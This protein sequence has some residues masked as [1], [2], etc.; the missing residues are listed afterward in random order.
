MITSENQKALIADIKETCH[1]KSVSLYD[2]KGSYRV[3]AILKYSFITDHTMEICMY[4]KDKHTLKT[5]VINEG[6]T[7]FI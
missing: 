2:L 7:Y 5:I 1:F 4:L 3:E 6:V